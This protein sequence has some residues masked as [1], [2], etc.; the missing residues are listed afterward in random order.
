MNLL[1]A[2]TNGRPVSFAI[3]AAAASAKPGAALM[4]V[5]GL[6]EIAIRNAVA[7]R[8]T[9]YHGTPDWTTAPKPP[10]EWKTKE[11]DG[12]RRAVAQARRAAYAKLDAAGKRSLDARAFPV[13]ARTGLSHSDRVSARQKAIAVPSGQIIAQLTLFYWKRLF[14]ADYEAT[15]WKPA[16][17]DLFPNKKVGRAEVAGHLEAL[18]EARN[19][20]AHHEPLYGSRLRRAL[21]AIDFVVENFKN[22]TPDPKS[23]LARL[24][25]DMRV[26]LRRE[27]AALEALLVSFRSPSAET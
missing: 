14:S 1:G 2:V 6:L 10:F 8:M 3:S 18:Y 13:G 4:P 15:L 22:R 7:N 5:T 25:V 26:D 21:A 27:V 9:A 16:L 12:I 24:T 17:R 11:Q 23:L 20:I 19:R